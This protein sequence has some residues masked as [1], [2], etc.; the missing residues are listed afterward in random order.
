MLM[1]KFHAGVFCTEKNGSFATISGICSLQLTKSD[2]NQPRA[3]AALP[4][5][6][7]QHELQRITDMKK[8][9][10]EL[11]WHDMMR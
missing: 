9:R 3:Y 5:I 11:K 6:I 7:S 4:G 2:Q 10:V 1:V 8:E